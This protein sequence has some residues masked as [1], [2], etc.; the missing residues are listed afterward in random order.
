MHIDTSDVH[1]YVH[2]L[3]FSSIVLHQ[4]QEEVI[5]AQQR[6]MRAEEDKELLQ[7]QLQQI[8]A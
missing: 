2:M 4:P 7:R 6:C 3:A 1:A 5:T 8:E